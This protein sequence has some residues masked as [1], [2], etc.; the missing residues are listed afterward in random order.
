[1]IPEELP[2]LLVGSIPGRWAIGTAEDVVIPSGGGQ[3]HEPLG[4]ADEGAV[5]AAKEARADLGASLAPAVALALPAT[6]G[7]I[8]GVA[9]GLAPGGTVVA[10]RLGVVGGGALA[11]VLQELVELSRGRQAIGIPGS[12]HGRGGRGDGRRGRDLNSGWYCAPM[13]KW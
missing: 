8:P 10:L 7:R 4:T 2:V 13:K 6:L 3:V 5:G 1:M 11:R 9:K 12:E